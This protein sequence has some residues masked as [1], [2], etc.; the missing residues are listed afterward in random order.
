MVC[1][2]SRAF[3]Q[4]VHPGDDLLDRVRAVGAVQRQVDGEALQADVLYGGVQLLAAPARCTPCRFIEDMH[5]ITT[6]APTRA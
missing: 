1:S 2:G 6:R 5:S 3:S 4:P